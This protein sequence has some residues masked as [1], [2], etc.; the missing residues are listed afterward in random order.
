MIFNPILPFSLKPK[1]LGYGTLQP[2]RIVAVRM[3]LSPAE[4]RVNSLKLSTKLPPRRIKVVAWQDKS[5]YTGEKLRAIRAKR[6]V[7]KPLWRHN[8]W[9]AAA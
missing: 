2:L 1:K 7:G 6:G 8:E 5:Y 9:R 4:Q 3:E